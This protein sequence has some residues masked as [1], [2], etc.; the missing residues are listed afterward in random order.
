MITRMDRDVG[1]ILGLLKELGLDDQTL[2]LFTSDNGGQSGDG[3]DLEFFKANGPLRGA[4]GTVYEGGVRV[5]MIA[6]WPGRIAPGRVDDFVWANWDVLP[7]LAEA[8]GVRPPPGLD[9]RSALERVLGTGP[10]RAPEFLYWEHPARGELLQ[11]VRMGKFKAVRLKRGAPLELYDLADDPGEFRDVAA[12]HPQVVA[13]IEE[14]LKTART[15]PRR[16]E[17][18]PRVDRKDYLH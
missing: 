11:G 18:Q 5:P 4:K 15:E 6:R 8:A 12:Q 9:G 16:Y 17:P 2:V 13:K 3:P 10:G 1:R 14:Y 7:T